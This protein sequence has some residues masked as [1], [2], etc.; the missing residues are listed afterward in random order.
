MASVMRRT[1][2]SMLLPLE[3]EFGD[4]R[5]VLCGL[6]KM[7]ANAVEKPNMIKNIGTM[8]AKRCARVFSMITLS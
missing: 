4:A 1:M 2:H 5:P 8:K 6:Y 7:H 3:S